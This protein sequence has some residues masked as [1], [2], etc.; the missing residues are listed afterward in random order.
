M[1]L[2][3]IFSEK[4]F[5]KGSILAPFHKDRRGECSQCPLFQ[6]PDSYLTNTYFK[7]RALCS[8]FGTYGPVLLLFCSFCDEVIP[9]H[10]ARLKIKICW[11]Q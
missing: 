4:V 6:H 2:D 1:F 3:L 9:Y 11:D 5:N 8:V 7:A 10:N